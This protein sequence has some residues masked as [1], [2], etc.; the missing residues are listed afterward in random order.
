MVVTDENHSK[1]RQNNEG[2]NNESPWDSSHAMQPLL[3]L[4][5]A[6]ENDSI[7]RQL[8]EMVHLRASQ[9]NGCSARS[10]CTRRC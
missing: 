3:A 10:T 4:G 2:T 7:S 6:A 5:K 1:R 9:I 8:R